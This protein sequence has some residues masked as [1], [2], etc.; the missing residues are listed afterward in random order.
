MRLRR[1]FFLFFFC[2]FFCFFFVEPFDIFF[3]CFTMNCLFSF[4]SLLIHFIFQALIQ[5]LLKSQQMAIESQSNLCGQLLPIQEK[6]EKKEGIEDLSVI[7]DLDEDATDDHIRV[8]FFIFTIIYFDIHSF[9][10]FRF[11][12]FCFTSLNILFSFL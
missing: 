8:H 2:F 4:F 6:V 1:F 9:I 5:S 3:L 11:L 10:Y 7:I 12:S